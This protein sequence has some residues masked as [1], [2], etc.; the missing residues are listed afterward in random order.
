MVLGVKVRWARI[1]RA[2]GS[3]LFEAI[4]LA[5]APPAKVKEEERNVAAFNAP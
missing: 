3:A 2:S 5:D 1:N 4:S